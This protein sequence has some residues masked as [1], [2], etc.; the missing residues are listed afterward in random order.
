MSRFTRDEILLIEQGR[1][2]LSQSQERKLLEKINVFPMEK[3]YAARREQGRLADLPKTVQEAV[4]LL[5][6]RHGS[7]SSLARLLRDED[8]SAQSVTLAR[9]KR[10]GAGKEVPPLPL[11][12]PP[13]STGS[14]NPFRAVNLYCNINDLWL[15]EGEGFEPTI[16]FSIISRKSLNLLMN[17][18]LL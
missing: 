12:K 4:T 10:I 13:E 11:L 5:A 18:K 9:L 2:S 3:V 14:S 16:R 6:E 15:A 17:S 7:Y 1:I 8:D